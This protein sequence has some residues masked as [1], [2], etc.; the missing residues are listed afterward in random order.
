[1]LCLQS[2][3]Q[4]LLS[5]EGD[6]EEGEQL[7]LPAAAEEGGLP[8]AAVVVS[9]RDGQQQGRGMGHATAAKFKADARQAA[10]ARFKFSPSH[11]GDQL[12]Q[13]QQLRIGIVDEDDSLLKRKAPAELSQVHFGMA[14]VRPRVDPWSA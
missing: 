13:A 2:G 11:A 3:K 4:H 9:S 1:M 6:E 5:F 14:Q 7:D 10:A 12:L 8:G